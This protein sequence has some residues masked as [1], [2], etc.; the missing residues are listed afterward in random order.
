MATTAWTCPDAAFASGSDGVLIH[1]VV[2]GMVVIGCHVQLVAV[3]SFDAGAAGANGLALAAAAEAAVLYT[4]GGRARGR[5][6][7]QPMGALMPTP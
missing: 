3:A 5:S 7:N 1:G 4:R 6:T 2:T